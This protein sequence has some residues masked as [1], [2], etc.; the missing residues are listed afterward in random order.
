MSE[1]NAPRRSTKG[2]IALIALAAVVVIALAAYWL[3]ADYRAYSRAVAL[4]DAG[5]HSGALAILETIPD[6]QDAPERINVCCYAVALEQEAAGSYA[7]AQAAFAALG[8]YK[9][10]PERAAEAGYQLAVALENTG[11]AQEAA[12]AF[13]ALG[14]YKDSAARAAN[15]ESAIERYTQ[16]AQRVQTQSDALRAALA[17][18]EALLAEGSAPL[19]EATRTELEA[20]VE[21][22]KAAEVEPPAEPVTLAEVEAAADALTKIDCAD[23]A[24]RTQSAVDA[25]ADSVARYALVDAPTVEFVADRLLRVEEIARI[26]VVDASGASVAA[27]D[28]TA[29]EAPAAGDA[30]EE[31]AAE[32]VAAEEAAAEDAVEEEVVAE[33]AADEDIGEEAVTE[34]AAD[35]EA[36]EEIVADKAADEEATEEAVA[37]ESADED[38]AED[39][40]ADE[41]A[42]E[43][44]VE[45]AVTDEATAENAA[46][47]AVTEEVADEEAAEEAIADEAADENA[48]EEAVAEE[49]ADE[50]VVEEAIADEAAD[51]DAAEEAVADK[52]ADE[53]IVE[54]AVTEEAADEDIAEEIVADK[55]ADEE[56]TEEAVADE[57]ADEDAVEEAIADEA[58]DEDAAEEAIV[59]EVADEDIAE[60][61]VAE[62]AADEDI[63]EE[64]VAEEAG[65]EETAGETAAERDAPIARVYFASTLVSEA[66]TYLPDEELIALGEACG[67]SVELYESAEAARRRD[68]ELDAQSGAHMAA[69]TLVIRLSDALSAL[70]RQAL[71]AEVLDSLTAA[72]PGEAVEREEQTR[73]L[74]E[75]LAVAETGFAVADGRLYYALVLVND[76]ANTTVEFP[77]VRVTFY[78]E[79][80]EVVAEDE[81][82]R[83][84]ICPG[85][86][87]A[88]AST[89]WGVEEAPAS[90]RAEIVAPRSRDFV[91]DA[92]LCAP[93]EVREARV[94][95]SGDGPVLRC[96]L[97][98]PNEF[99][100]PSAA[101]TI[102]YRDGEG[103]L[104]SGE[105][106]WCEAIPAGGSTA[107]EM[108]LTAALVQDNFEVY[109]CIG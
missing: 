67:G 52:A 39:A 85:Q 93:L 103:V 74:D 6:Y 10:A 31:T 29:E 45:E 102:L 60:E 37:D 87:L 11:G 21:A 84:A 64:A 18:G 9:D 58:A 62:E 82:V 83:M 109:A 46:E 17:A 1:N 2:K 90:A 12:D 98:N 55:A 71:M 101:V 32:E 5:D 79:A 33:E 54:E 108:P 4:Q 76:M 20:C 14:N 16:E 86:R 27:A 26:A 75:V 36:A 80:G 19:D 30:A 56:A 81:A 66:Y 51:E 50:E 69:G 57:A 73:S 7:E 24:Q 35:E 34:E 47:E 99:D 91:N 88:W 61:A 43:D 49:A 38:A 28:G 96:E 41:A 22:G 59:D 72:Q 44:I 78:D 8:D 95:E 105:S 100:A 23:L 89:V 106:A 40:V 13:A 65:A 94:E 107:F 63:A 15:L 77:R 97:Y 70:E 68:D 42:G 92:A 48:A 25:Y 53:D 3:T 104:L